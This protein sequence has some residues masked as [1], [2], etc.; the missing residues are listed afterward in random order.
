LRIVGSGANEADLREQAHA[1]G[2]QGAVDFLPNSADMAAHYV[3]ASIFVLS[4]R[5]EGFGL[6]LT[7]AKAFGLPVVSFNCAC[8][9]SDIVR[10]GVDGTLVPPG[11]VIA[12]AGALRHLMTDSVKRTAYGKE[13]RRDDRFELNSVAETWMAL[14]RSGEDVK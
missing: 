1:L 8:G 14:L 10:D 13:A 6:V 11:D 4:S 2:I 9:P 7:E 3:S 12:L 5:F